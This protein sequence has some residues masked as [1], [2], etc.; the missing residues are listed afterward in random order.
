M[1]TLPGLEAGVKS[2]V[3]YIG[4]YSRSGSTLLLRLLAGDGACVAVGEL[5]NIWSRGYSENQLCGCGSPFR[6]C[7]FWRD[8]TREAFGTSVERL[9]VPQLERLHGSLFRYP[10]FPALWA[11]S[12]RSERFRQAL[13]D[14][15]AVMRALYSSIAKVAGASCIVD[16]SKVPQFYRVLTELPSVEVHLIH[17]VRDSRATAFSWQRS[18]PRPEIHWKREEMDRYSVVRSSAEWNAFNAL[19]AYDRQRGASYTHVRYEDLVAAPNRVV[20]SI[21]KAV[22]E[23]GIEKVAMGLGSVVQLPVSHTVAGNP[24]R[25]RSGS[26]V[27][28]ADQEW[29]TRMPWWKRTTVTLLTAPLLRAHGYALR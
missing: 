25:F 5:V 9:N 21:G 12:M 23:G 6:E 4:G 27:I 19:L 20:S 29:R 22:A 26:V 2:K 1:E 7:W 8:V 14:Y 10:S 17:L 24:S 15:D 11:P 3:L 28:D 16:S 18:K 13:A